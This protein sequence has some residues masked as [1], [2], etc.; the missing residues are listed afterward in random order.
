MAVPYKAPGGF[1]YQSQYESNPFPNENIDPKIKETTEFGIKMAAAIYYKWQ[2]EDYSGGY[3]FR[4]NQNRMYA[5][6]RQNI[7][8][9]KPFLDQ[10]L[11]NSGD[12]SWMNIDWSIESPL[13]LIV[14]RLLGRLMNIDFKIQANSIDGTAAIKKT[15][16]RDKL[17]GKMY[18]RKTA[19]QLE[20][21][22]GIE[23]KKLL[24][25]FIRIL[26]RI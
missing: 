8:Q 3:R 14:K 7:D 19:A 13:P 12:K 23:M 10:I 17:L 9:Y 15:Q 5:R 4:V 2:Y 1:Q 11:D 26:D 16:E 24:F 20:K 18:Q 25:F 6:G 21:I 22:A